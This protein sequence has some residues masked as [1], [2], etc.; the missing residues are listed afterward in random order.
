M[1]EFAASKQPRNPSGEYGTPQT[2]P[3]PREPL[4]P[5]DLSSLY[6]QR[7]VLMSL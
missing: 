7:S 5:I 4:A 3:R 1:I 6:T 2:R